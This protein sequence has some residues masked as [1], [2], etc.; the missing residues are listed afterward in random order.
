VLQFVVEKDGSI[1][2]MKVVRSPDVCYLQ[3]ATLYM[4]RMPLW[5]PGK[6]NGEIVPCLYTLPVKYKFIE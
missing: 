6:R 1:T 2:D 4:D 5:L 3:A